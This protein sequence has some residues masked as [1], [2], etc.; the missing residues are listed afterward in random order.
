MESYPPQ[1]GE[2]SVRLL[3]LEPGAVVALMSPND[4]TLVPV[5]WTEYSAAVEGVLGDNGL[6]NVVLTDPVHQN[7]SEG[8]VLRTAN[9]GIVVGEPAAWPFD[10]TN[11]TDA[12]VV[13][14]FTSGQRMELTLSDDS[15][16]AYRWS[17]DMMFTQA[18]EDV[19]LPAGATL[20]FML[21]AEPL[22][23]PPGTYTA[24]AWVKAAEAM[25]LSLE[26]QVTISS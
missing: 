4:P 25:D 17:S 14:T 12:D 2:P 21:T 20:P 8:L 24:K 15:G 11:G 22:D 1:C 5:S 3:D 9:L 6:S 26:W 16:E 7:G 10:L 18:I 13:L 23:L 19:P